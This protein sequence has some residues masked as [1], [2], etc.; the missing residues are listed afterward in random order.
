ML[1]VQSLAVGVM[2]HVLDSCPTKIAEAPD[3]AHASR[4]WTSYLIPILLMGILRR[5]G[6]FQLIVATHM[7]GTPGVSLGYLN[8]LGQ[9]NC[10]QHKESSCMNSHA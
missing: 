5:R 1:C 7:V 2:G 4:G 6:S 8:S 10:W 9:G 3:V